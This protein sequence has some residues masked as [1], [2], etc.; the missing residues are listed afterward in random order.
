MTKQ[1]TQ[2]KCLECHSTCNLAA[3]Y[4]EACGYQFR[5]APAPAADPARW[6]YRLAAV[7]TGLAV[8]IAFHVVRMIMAG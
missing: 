6:K 4:C 2:K 7:V 1:L 8:A 5:H 3:P